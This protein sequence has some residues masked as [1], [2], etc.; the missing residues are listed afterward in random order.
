MGI[1]SYDV[2]DVAE[3]DVTFKNKAGVPTDPT[4]VELRIKKPDGTVQIETA[5][6]PIVKDSTGVYHFNFTVAMPGYHTYRW[7]G[8]GAVATAEEGIFNVRSS[9]VLV[10]A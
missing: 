5:L 7:K 10:G 8:T 3:L 9:T 6:P 4:T 1:K 2:D